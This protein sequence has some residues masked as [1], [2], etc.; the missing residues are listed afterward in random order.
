MGILW[1]KLRNKCH[2]LLYGQPG[3]RVHHY[4]YYVS[5]TCQLFTVYFWVSTTG[6]GA[7]K[8]IDFP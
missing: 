7:Q 3:Q 5:L 8:L 2:F 4:S 1:H 6:S